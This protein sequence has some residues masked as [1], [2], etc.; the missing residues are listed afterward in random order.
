MWEGSKWYSTHEILIC[1]LGWTLSSF[2]CLVQIFAVVRSNSCSLGSKMIA[3][4]LCSSQNVHAFVIFDFV[5]LLLWLCFYSAC[6][7]LEANDLS[8]SCGTLIYSYLYLDR[9][10]KIFGESS[11]EYSGEATIDWAK[12][13]KKNTNPII[14]YFRFKAIALPFAFGTKLSMQHITYDPKIQEIIPTSRSVCPVYTK[15]PWTNRQDLQ[16]TTQAG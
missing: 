13:K 2:G 14:D 15:N 3:V 11:S 6:P 8:W 9:N 5:S 10:Q 16:E 7:F 1:G 4:G 12:K